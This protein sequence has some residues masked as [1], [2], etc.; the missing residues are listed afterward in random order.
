[1]G[2]SCN[3]SSLL[4]AWSQRWLLF[5]ATST[6][7]FLIL[8]NSVT[9]DL[10]HFVLWTQDRRAGSYLSQLY[11]LPAVSFPLTPSGWLLMSPLLNYFL[12]MREKSA[13]QGQGWCVYVCMYTHF[14]KLFR[15]SFGQFLSQIFLGPLHLIIMKQN[16]KALSQSVSALFASIFSQF[17]FD[18][19]SMH[20]IYHCEKN[21]FLFCRS[22]R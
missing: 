4:R 18:Y 15:F 16:N 19:L 9:T 21:N 7:G 22:L 17:N 5:E 1:M 20:S 14:L 2:N 8:L 10:S 13:F 11:K 3:F 12:I 6:S